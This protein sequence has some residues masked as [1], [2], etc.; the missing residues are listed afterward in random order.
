MD[1]NLMRASGVKI[2][3]DERSVLRC[4]HRLD[5][6]DCA[7]SVFAHAERDRPDAR[8][9]RIDE[10]ILSELTFDEREIA[11]ADLFGFKLSSEIGIDLRQ[12]R[13]ENHAARAA[14]ESLHQEE[15]SCVR[16]RE[17]EQH[18]LTRVVGTLDDAVCWFVDEEESF[19][20]VKN[21]EH[22]LPV[23]G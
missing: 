19:V 10:L 3:C 14:I 20:F 13:E 5:G 2:D 23:T 4:P 11:L 7:L 15:V 22:L 17:L 9:R 18:R 6:S 8:E 1:A 12:L 21:L 16:L